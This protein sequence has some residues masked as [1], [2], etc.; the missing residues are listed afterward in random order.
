MHDELHCECAWCRAD[1]KLPPLP[2]GKKP[3]H[4]ICPECLKAE[5]PDIWQAFQA[6]DKATIELVPLPEESSF[7]A[8]DEKG[9]TS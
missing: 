7:S 4:G 3:S 1:G 9:L 8:E 5:F 6:A 2:E